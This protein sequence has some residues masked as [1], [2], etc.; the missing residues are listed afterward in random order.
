M[1]VKGKGRTGSGSRGWGREENRGG[2]K[3]GVG[4]LVE[5]T[6]KWGYIGEV[7]EVGGEWK[8]REKG[9]GDRDREG[10]GKG[11]GEVGKEEIGGSKKGDFNT[12][13]KADG[14]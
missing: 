1:V 4:N 8:K 13:T 14:T 12:L 5:K 10:G 7:E 6:E 11:G 3:K 2:G 9:Q